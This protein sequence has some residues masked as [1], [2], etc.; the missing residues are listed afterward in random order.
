MP[1]KIIT[2]KRCRNDVA[3]TSNR[4]YFNIA[5]ST[6]N[7]GAV[8]LLTNSMFQ[9]NQEWRE[10][11]CFLKHNNNPLLLLSPMKVEEIKKDPFLVMF[12]NFFTDREIDKIK[13][14]AKPRVFSHGLPFV[15][16]KPLNPLSAN[17]N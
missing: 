8:I 3:L 14:L 11:R 4:R 16:R 12:H 15:Y 7:L 9:I 10:L 2:L 6:S 13:D 17:R 5:M 1:S